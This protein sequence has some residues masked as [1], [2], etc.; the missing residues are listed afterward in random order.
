MSV[1]TQSSFGPYFFNRAIYIFVSSVDE[2][3]RANQ[4][5]KLRHRRKKILDSLKLRHFNLPK[6][7]FVLLT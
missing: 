4:L 2:I 3:R 5:G 1:T 7:N 6:R